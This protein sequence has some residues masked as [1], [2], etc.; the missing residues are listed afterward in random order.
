MLTHNGYIKK[1][2]EI[3]K[4]YVNNPV[5]EPIAA[6]AIDALVLQVIGEDIDMS[7]LSRNTYINIEKLSK[8][9]VRAEQRK[10]VQGEQS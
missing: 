9:D 10:T 1:R 2:D 8:N 6:Q 4:K 5:F 3:T 7:V